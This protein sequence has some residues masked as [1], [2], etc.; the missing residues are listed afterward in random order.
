MGKNKK[1]SIIENVMDELNEEINSSSKDSSNF[2]ISDFV[3]EEHSPAKKVSDQD[4]ESLI[5]FDPYKEEEKEEGE[6]GSLSQDKAVNLLQNK[7]VKTRSKVKAKLNQKGLDQKKGSDQKRTD[8]K[9]VEQK[10][11]DQKRTD[12]KDVEQKGSDQ[13]DKPDK[14]LA[15]KLNKKSQSE[16]QSVKGKEEGADT[17]EVSKAEKSQSEAQSIKGKEEGADTA[18]VSKAEKSQSEAQ[19]VKG[20]EEGADTAEVSKAKKSQSEAQSIKGKEEGADTA[21]VSKAEKSQSEAQSIKGKEELK[22]KNHP[23]LRGS[24]A[25]NEHNIQ[26]EPGAGMVWNR[27]REGIGTQSNI[28]MRITLQQS[29]NLRVAQE[30]IVALETE[31]ERLRLENEDLIATG[32]IFRE[33]L[34]K[35]IVQNDNLKKTYEESRQEFQHEKRTLLDTL[36][37]Q[38]LEIEK[39]N[40]KNKD[41]EKRL[42]SN[43]QQIRVRERDLE[44]RL[45]L[46]KL[47]NQT[48]AREKDQ[49]ILDL[50]R[51]IDRM[52]MESDTQK[53][54]HNE[55]SNKLEGYRNQNRNVVR[56][57]QVVL[58]VARGANAPQE[59]HPLPF[60]QVKAE[61]E[62]EAQ[63]ES[64]KK[65]VGD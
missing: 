36:N 63:E 10:G 17:A 51:Q 8:Q 38:T 14:N 52:K 49:Y 50:K 37:S 16:A 19:S 57:L 48:L 28:P 21:E 56:G 43:I 6:K 60:T 1:V 40:V 59:E 20:K 41:L 32:D 47:D 31:I 27:H 44:N 64:E 65:V 53:N 42:F 13:K 4:L 58:N 61:E 26:G 45:E 30:R 29:E 12:Q 23:L 34:D 54:K 25:L 7:A 11:S 22:P 15:F 35:I 39:M 55:V 2:F 46:M 5:H 9:G 33:R 3:K 18:E 62:K 24:P